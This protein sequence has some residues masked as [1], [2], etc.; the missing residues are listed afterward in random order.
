MDDKIQAAY[1][2][3]ADQPNLPADILLDLNKMKMIQIKRKMHLER[4]CHLEP[5]ECE[6]F[7][8]PE[9]TG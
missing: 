2:Q 6:E 8:V 4:T 3:W 5:P 9:P 7:S 1:Q